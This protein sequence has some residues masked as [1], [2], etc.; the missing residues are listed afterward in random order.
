MRAGAEVV[1][2]ALQRRPQVGALGQADEG[3]AH[4]AADHLLAELD[5]VSLDRDRRL[6]ASNSFHLSSSLVVSWEHRRQAF[7]KRSLLR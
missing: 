4:A 1:R 3:D 7:P 6:G 5:A 2:Q